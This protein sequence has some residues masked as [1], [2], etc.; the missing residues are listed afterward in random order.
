MTR[1]VGKPPKYNNVEE[2]DSAIESYFFLCDSRTR[3][4]MSVNGEGEIVEMEVSDPE[5][6]TITGLALHLGFCDKRS[7]YDY[8]E[9]EQYSHSI[10][11]AKTRIENQIEKEVRSVRNAAGQIFLLKNFGW[12]DRS[13]IEHSVDNS[14]AERIMSARK[15]AAESSGA[16][17][18]Q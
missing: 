10:K 8:E 3:K 16:N 9:K 6:Y 12:K 4:Q 15:R 5:E 14:L 7:L 13:E 18:P 11:R 17:A 1:S 2:L